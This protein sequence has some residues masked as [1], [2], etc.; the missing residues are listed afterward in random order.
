MQALGNKV[1][2]LVVCAIYAN[3]PSEMRGMI[4]EPTP[5]GA[6]KVVLATNVA[7]TSITIDGVVFVTDP[8]FVKRNSF[9]PRTGMSSLTVVPV[10]ISF[11]LPRLLTNPS[12]IKCLRAS[13][14]HCAG[15][16]ERIGPGKALRLYTKWVSN[17]ELEENTIPEIQ[18][19]NLGMIFLLLKSLGINDLIG[20]EFMDPPGETLIR[21]LEMLYALGAL[22]DRGE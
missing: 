16:A 19:T 1:R 21:E 20:F 14:N 6:R 8:G 17:N 2:E 4:P 12:S 11:L 5:E 3:F 15:R 10:R 22:N 18:R 9:N 7:E 13:A